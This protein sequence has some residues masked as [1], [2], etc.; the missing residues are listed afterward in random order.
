MRGRQQKYPYYRWN[1]GEWHEVHPSEYGKSI[2]TLRATLQQW[3][4]NNRRQLITRTVG[5]DTLAICF[6]KLS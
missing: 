5:E 4:K 1:N 3:A 2:L 6:K